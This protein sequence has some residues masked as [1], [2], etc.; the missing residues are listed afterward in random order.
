MAGLVL[1]AQAAGPANYAQVLVD[2]LMRT[3]PDLVRCTLYTA[4]TGSEGGASVLASNVSAAAA[5]ARV[6]AAMATETTAFSRTPNG[7]F[8]GTLT[9]YNRNDQP[10]G[11]I[12]LACRYTSAH[13]EPRF[14]NLMTALRNGLKVKIPDRGSLAG[15]A[16]EPAR[17]Y[18]Q[19]LMERMLAD[20]PELIRCSIH[21]I[22]PL[23]RV[24]NSMNIAYAD[25]LPLHRLGG[26]S[27]HD[28]DYGVITT[29]HPLFYFWDKTPFNAAPMYKGALPL[30]D[31]KG[32]QIGAFI[33]GF[34][35]TGKENEA[36]LREKAATLRD[37][38]K[39]FIPDND[40]LF[41]ETVPPAKIRIQALLES[42]TAANAAIGRCAVYATPP[43]AAVSSTYQ[44]A[45]TDLADRGKPADTEI[46]DVHTT[47]TES[48]VVRDGGKAYRGVLPL[49]DRA[50]AHA[51]VLVVD[52][53]YSGQ[54]GEQA[55]MK[56]ATALRD[57]LKGQ[58]AGPSDLFGPV[59]IIEP[60][61]RRSAPAAAVTADLVEKR[62][63][64]QVMVDETL[65]ANPDLAAMDIHARKTGTTVLAR[66]ASNG[67][68]LGE[69]GGPDEMAAW[70]EGKTSQ[71]S[72][73]GSASALEIVLPLKAAPGKS[74]GAVTFVFKD[75][76]G[77]TPAGQ[78]ARA[79]AL[80]DVLASKTPSMP[81]LFRVP[82]P[83]M[84]QQ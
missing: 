48:W 33:L 13:D 57:R 3:E 55:L 78:L 59:G 38:L 43:G 5:G 26:H 23:A 71:R 73:P 37:S 7:D 17:I 44:V 9:L 66:V 24:V 42:E 63:Y 32:V 19:F 8:E 40:T 2:E 25:V 65:A 10:V 47:G 46:F 34:V 14:V 28:E 70:Q 39:I 30:Y 1:V 81:S 76:P 54:A 16:R 72:V 52:M 58:L 80:R 15:P 29:G 60:V 64:S 27:D 62:I 77:L 12:V 50:N 82:A 4:S 35:Y 45:G 53:K 21:A 18:A 84:C 61:P 75:A 36:G 51:G 31:R 41:T 69:P 67:R 49:Y 6:A 83:W 22:P 74:L 68:T 79:R 20:H 56:T 11:A